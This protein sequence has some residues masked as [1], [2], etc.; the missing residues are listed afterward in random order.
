[1]A[2]PTVLGRE[3]G[4]FPARAPERE[5]K[6]PSTTTLSQK[7]AEER[8]VL[9]LWEIKTGAASGPTR[10]IARENDECRRK[11]Q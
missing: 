5:G 1:M 2:A 4:E 6:A 9:P 3:A 11:M 8:D 7:A 10:T